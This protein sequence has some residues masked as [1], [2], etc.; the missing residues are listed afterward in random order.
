MC[1]QHWQQVI[2]D[3]MWWECTNT[4]VGFQSD[5]DMVAKWYWRSIKMLIYRPHRKLLVWYIRWGK[6]FVCHEEDHFMLISTRNAKSTT[7]FLGNSRSHWRVIWNYKCGFYQVQQLTQYMLHEL[8]IWFAR[9]YWHCVN[10]L[11]FVHKFILLG[12]FNWSIWL[13]KTSV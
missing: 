3:N 11:H 10:L 8:Q 5:Y 12:N 7:C 2:I 4:T 9:K 6:W 13:I 1:W